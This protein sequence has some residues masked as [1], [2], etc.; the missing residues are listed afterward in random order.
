MTDGTSLRMTSQRPYLLRGLYAWIADNGMT[1]Y[2]LVD[3]TR[4]GVRVPPAAMSEGRVVLNIAE[5]AVAGLDMGNEIILFTARVSGVSHPVRVPM[6]AVLGIYA[7]ETGHGMM[8]PDDIPGTGADPQV[9]GED[10]LED[11]EGED[12]DGG[13]DP[14]PSPK[15]GSHL[16]VIK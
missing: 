16:R 11:I 12:G 14:S 5:R 10:I 3:A 1:P 9:E 8:L 15:R 13:D 4:P 7:R 6:S 2:L